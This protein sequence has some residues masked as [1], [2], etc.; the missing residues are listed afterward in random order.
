[1]FCEKCGNEL[2]DDAVICTKCGCF[3]KNNKQ[4]IKNIEQKNKKEDS[5]GFFSWTSFIL[6]L[7]TIF[8]SIIYLIY[9]V[10]SKFIPFIF[11]IYKFTW[12]FPSASLC[13]LLSI[14]TL[15]KKYNL[16]SL[17]GLIISVISLIIDL[18]VNL[19]FF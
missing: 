11:Y 15:R 19:A 3:I 17:F 18:V 1:M 2:I 9:L 13:V 16:I 7:C 12:I 4:R 14:Y 6:A 5:C 8:S 10:S